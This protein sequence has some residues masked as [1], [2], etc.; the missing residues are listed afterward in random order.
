MG[1]SVSLSRS[2]DPNGNNNVLGIRDSQLYLLIGNVFA[3]YDEAI[4][5]HRT[6]EDATK[7]L[8][9]R[10]KS[11]KRFSIGGVESPNPSNIYF[12]EVPAVNGS[13]RESSASEV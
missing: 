9:N 6:I 1:S 12:G 13:T 8:Q 10:L 11:Y 7:A 5:G 2:N 4:L 3:I